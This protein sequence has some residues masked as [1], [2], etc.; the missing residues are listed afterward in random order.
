MCDKACANPCNPCAK[1]DKKAAKALE[2]RV[3]AVCQTALVGLI[4]SIWDLGPISRA[5]ANMIK[6][7]PAVTDETLIGL[8]HE[9]AKTLPKTTLAR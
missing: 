6:S 4:V 2:K 5:C 1:A 9:F 7:Q 8:L 3:N